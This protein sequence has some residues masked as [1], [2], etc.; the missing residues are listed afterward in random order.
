MMEGKFQTH[1]KNL[2]INIEKWS[3]IYKHCM[4]YLSSLVISLKQRSTDYGS[5]QLDSEKKQE[6]TSTSN[7]KWQYDAGGCVPTSAT[8][9]TSSYL[10][11]Y[12]TCRIEI[13]R[14]AKSSSAYVYMCVRVFVCVCICTYG[15]CNYIKCNIEF[16]TKR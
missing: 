9:L 7:L 8:S 1:L 5:Y 14:I 13:K 16:Y 12:R 2:S 3:R 10:I 15:A 11:I 4:N 6:T